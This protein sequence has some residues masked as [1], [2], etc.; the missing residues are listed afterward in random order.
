M[1]IRW[2][3]EAVANLENL[4][5]H[6]AEDSPPAAFKTANEIYEGIEELVVFPNRGRKGRE[7]GTRE[8][9]LAPLPYI[10]IYRVK[11]S[12]VEILHIYHGAQDWG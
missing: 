4:C 7:E 11:D 6:I 2:T 9:V 12:T 1:N 3:T 8:L 5:L 10:A